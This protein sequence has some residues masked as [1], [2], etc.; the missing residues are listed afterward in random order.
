M[1]SCIGVGFEYHVAAS[2]ADN[3][4]AMRVQIVEEAPHRGDRPLGILDCDGV[5]ISVAHNSFNLVLFIIKN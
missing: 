4:R 3:L 2:E 1:E 5:E